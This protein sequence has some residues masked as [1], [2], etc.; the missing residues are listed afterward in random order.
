[1]KKIMGLFC[2]ALL[3]S[4][5]LAAQTTKDKI[6]KAIKDPKREENAAKADVQL[7]NDKKISD[8]GSAVI[9]QSVAPK[10]TT[11]KKTKK[12]NN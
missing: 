10:K 5:A 6:D 7:F 12:K 1:M 8:T 4:G 9:N 3:I 11:K 2:G